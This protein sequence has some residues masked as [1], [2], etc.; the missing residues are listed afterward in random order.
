MTQQEVD[1]IIDT[2]IID[3]N[4]MQVSPAKV[5]SVCKAINS[6][7]QTGD[8][9]V[10]TAVAPL[11]FDPFTN[12]FSIQQSGS[13]TDGYLSKED[14][15][16]FNDGSGGGGD[17]IPLSGTEE[18]SPITGGLEFNDLTKI[19]TKFGDNSFSILTDIENNGEV[20]F[21]YKDDVNN[22]FRRLILL[23]NNQLSFQNLYL[24]DEISK[25][26]I[27]SVEKKDILIEA[28]N[29]E[30][31]GILGNT[32]FD[33]QNDPN[34]FAQLGDVQNATNTSITLIA[35]T[36]VA[37]NVVNKEAYYGIQTAGSLLSL[38]PVTGN[39][40]KKFIIA[41]LSSGFVTL[42]SNNGTDLDILNFG[43]AVNELPIQGGNV[44][45]L[46]NDGLKWVVKTIISSSIIDRTG[47][48]VKFDKVA[49]YGTPTTPITGNITF[50]FTN[51]KK[52][53]IQV[54][55]HQS[56]TAPTLPASA[57]ILNSSGY[58]TSHKNMILF[59]FS[60]P[61]RVEVSYNSMG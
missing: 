23:T 51:A 5:R 9:S 33:K 7:I 56:A 22:S 2:L 34:A 35:D 43:T 26:I 8:A 40:S 10:V 55:Y 39:E 4:T 42:Y 28:Y 52:G 13:E 41:N 53:M 46:F 58:E 20:V 24:E 57:Y 48:S 54:M 60:E 3:N 36:T 30:S 45:T 1:N 21:D 17:F 59:C 47:A 49:T 31:K 11:E 12:N 14:W 6:R 15:N 29:V 50:D 25:G 18:G 61:G 16:T 38:P 32:L 19:Y 27:L 44:I 37:L